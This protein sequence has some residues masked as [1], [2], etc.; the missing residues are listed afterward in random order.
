MRSRYFDPDPRFVI[1]LRFRGK[2]RRPDIP[3]SKI[4]FGPAGTMRDVWNI[5]VRQGGH[6]KVMTPEMPVRP[7][8]E[9]Q[10]VFLPRPARSGFVAT[11]IIIPVVGGSVLPVRRKVTVT[12]GRLPPADLGVLSVTSCPIS[13]LNRSNI[14]SGHLRRCSQMKTIRMFE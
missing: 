11:W 5:E 14:E 2:L 3:S 10:T 1:I 12:G 8:R 9:R 4:A 6:V 7:R 13:E